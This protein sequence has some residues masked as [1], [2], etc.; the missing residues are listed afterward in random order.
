MRTGSCTCISTLEE[1]LWKKCIARSFGADFPSLEEISSHS[2]YTLVNSEP[3]IEFAAPTLSRVINIG[4]IGA[5]EPKA[6][7]EEWNRILSR[8]S[9]TIIY[10]FGSVAKTAQLPEAIKQSIITVINRFLDI[11]FIWKYEDIT[12]SFANETALSLP[13]LVLS[14]WIPQNDLLNDDRITLFIMHGG[15]GSTQEIAMRGKPGIFVPLFGDQPRNAGM[16]EFNGL[17]KVLDKFDLTNPDKV[18][19]VIR[20]VLNNEKYAGNARKV[21][22]MLKKKTIRSKRTSCQNC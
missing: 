21:A 11:T 17:G 19:A 18:E 2:A 1:P 8:R 5:K 10:S 12:D 6:L 22:A 14:P 13:N 3:L 7:D 15:M 20:E 16:M 4:G 9:K